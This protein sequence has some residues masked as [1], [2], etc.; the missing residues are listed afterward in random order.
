MNA[1]DQAALVVSVAG[2]VAGIAVAA[3][4]HWREGLKA[5]LELWVAAGLLRLT[6]DPDIERIAAAAA[7]ITVRR[8]ASHALRG[9]PL[10]GQGHPERSA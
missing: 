6:F 7:I 9:S 4:G 5:S 3:T 2:I 1:A 8:L 10:W